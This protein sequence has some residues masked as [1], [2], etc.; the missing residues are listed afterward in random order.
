MSATSAT[1]GSDV[2]ELVQL[3]INAGYSPNPSK[4]KKRG[5]HYIFTEDIETAIKAFQAYHGLKPN[6][7]LNQITLTQLKTYKK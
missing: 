3:L 7:E 5:T 6:G 4:L 2:D 1:S